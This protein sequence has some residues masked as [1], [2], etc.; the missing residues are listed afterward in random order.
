[1]EYETLTGEDINNLL[2]VNKKTVVSITPK[3]EKSNDNHEKAVRVPK[4]ARPR[5]RTGDLDPT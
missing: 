4:I 2:N 3:A 5:T 1:M